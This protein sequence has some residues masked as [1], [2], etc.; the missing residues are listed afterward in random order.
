M[1]S[2]LRI[3]GID[4]V[5]MPSSAASTFPAEKLAG[6]DSALDDTPLSN[7]PSVRSLRRVGVIDVGSNSVRLVVFDGAARSPAYFYNEKIL[8]GLG[9]E[10]ARTGRLDQNGRQRALSAIKRFAVLSEGMEVSQLI[11]VATAA[12]RDA[13]DGLEFRDAVERE[14]GLR[15]DIVSGEEEARLSAQG[16]ILGWP[17]AAGLVCDLG[18]SSMELAEIQDRRIGRCLTSQL[19]PFAVNRSAE[20]S[21]AKRE[22]ID[23]T[24]ASLRRQIPEEFRTLYLVG[25]CWRAIARLDMERRAYP[26]KVLNEYTVPAKEILQTMKW[27]AKSNLSHLRRKSGNSLDRLRLVPTA[28][29]ILESLVRSFRPLEV[30][31]SAYGIREGLLYDRM[32]ERL[33]QRDPLIEACRHAEH[34]SARLPGYGKLLFEFIRPLFKAATDGQLRLVHAACLLHD[35]TWRAHPDYRAEVSFDNATRANLGG[36]DH[37]GRVF[38]ALALFHRYKNPGIVKRSSRLTG[39]LAREEAKRAEILGKALRFGAMF[40][41]VSPEKI[42][43]LKFR[44][45]KHSLTLMLPEALRDIYGEV[46]AVRFHALAAAMDCTPEVVME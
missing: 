31:T 5:D 19:G 1:S 8:C 23:G 12:V 2:F 28:G 11:G 14:T 38:L 45:K 24:V 39:L 34:S 26:L 16:V 9:A 33:R 6:P 3:Q 20:G 44:S 46:V 17:D 35:V 37:A 27:I 21:K 4:L 32:P 25:G 18:G 22:L 36:L 13:V 43:R 29:L 42:V 15:L 40:T 30:A 41:V 7:D 10:L